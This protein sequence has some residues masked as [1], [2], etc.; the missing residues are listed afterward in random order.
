MGRLE[1]RGHPDVRE[2]DPSKSLR[3]VVGPPPCLAV[4]ILVLRYPRFVNVALLPAR[5]TAVPE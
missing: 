5:Q 2:K 1:L 4:S 3:K